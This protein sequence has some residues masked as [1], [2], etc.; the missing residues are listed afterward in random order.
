MLAL[1]N[2]GMPWLMGQDMA[3]PAFT[4]IVIYASLGLIGGFHMWHVMETRYIEE[5][6]NNNIAAHNSRPD[7]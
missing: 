7:A 2:V 1:V 3:W 5:C 4:D 6:K